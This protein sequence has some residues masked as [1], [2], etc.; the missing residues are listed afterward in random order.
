MFASYYSRLVSIYL[1]LAILAALVVGVSAVTSE[2]QYQNHGRYLL[3]D[4]ADDPFGDR[5]S[6]LYRDLMLRLRPSN[7]DISRV[8]NILSRSNQRQK[9]KDN[10]KKH[11]V[12]SGDSDGIEL[13]VSPWGDTYRPLQKALGMKSEIAQNLL[14][15]IGSQLLFFETIDSVH[16]SFQPYEDSLS[17]LQRAIGYDLKFRGKTNDQS[18]AALRDWAAVYGGWRGNAH[19]ALPLFLLGNLNLKRA[20]SSGQKLGIKE[21]NCAIENY[22]EAISFLSK[23]HLSKPFIT[24]SNNLGLAFFIRS[25]FTGE[26][27]RGIAAIVKRL[28][29]NQ[30]SE[31]T[32]RS[33]EVSR[34]RAINYWLLREYLK[35]TRLKKRR[36]S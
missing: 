6:L 35:S 16:F 4:L 23:D 36:K 31:P 10:A 8:R 27:A 7:P 9:I 30:E 24:I 22:F 17:Y 28:G 20:V 5:S 2:D 1:P 29:W 21:L 33:H 25:R 32:L 13:R 14:G 12:I 18:E 3:F 15:S 26:P 19:R 11:I 34:V